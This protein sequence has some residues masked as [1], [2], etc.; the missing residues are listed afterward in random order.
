MQFWIIHDN[1]LLFVWGWNNNNNNKIQ[2]MFHMCFSYEE[3][4]LVHGSM[5]DANKRQP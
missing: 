4:T 5:A 1:I 3:N 2:L